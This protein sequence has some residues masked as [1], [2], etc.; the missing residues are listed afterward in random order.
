MLKL[1]PTHSRPEAINA[2]Q[3]I[4]FSMM[5]K[6]GLNGL[7]QMLEAAMGGVL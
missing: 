5:G 3:L 1:D 4:D 6:L 2:N 7:F